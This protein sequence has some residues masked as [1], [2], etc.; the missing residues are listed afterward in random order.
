MTKETAEILEK[1]LTYLAGRADSEPEADD[2]A[3]ALT[4]S[5]SGERCSH[6]DCGKK[7]EAS[8]YHHNR[9]K[10]LHYCIPHLHGESLE[11]GFKVWDQCPN[12]QCLFGR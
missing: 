4:A 2:L 9:E 3:D 8:I 10:V 5:V 11:E 1:V 6:P 12:C 7:A